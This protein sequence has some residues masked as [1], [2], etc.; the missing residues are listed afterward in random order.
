MNTLLRLWSWYLEHPEE[1]LLHLAAL[2]SLCWIAGAVIFAVWQAHVEKQ[3]RQKFD[4]IMQASTPPPPRAAGFPS[5]RDFM[6]LR[7]LLSPCLLG[8]AADPLIVMRGKQAR[9]ECRRCQ[10]DLGP[11]LAG[12]KFKARRVKVK[13]QAS[14]KVLKLA[15]GQS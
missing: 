5:K 12:Q 4:R 6:N 15:R 1:L 7:V 2:L 10:S 9:F 14:A 11:V 13:K 8:H 3:A